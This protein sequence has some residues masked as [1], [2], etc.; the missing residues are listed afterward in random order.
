MPDLAYEKL[1]QS[2]FMTLGLM[3]PAARKPGQRADV[4]IELA[5]A[6]RADQYGFSALW[7]SQAPS[8]YIP[9]AERAVFDDPFVWLTA[10]GAAAPNAALVAQL[11]LSRYG[12][13]QLVSSARSLQRMSGGRCVLGLS[14][15]DG[16]DIGRLH[17]EKMLAAD[18]A[19]QVPILHLDGAVDRHPVVRQLYLELDER[20]SAP[21]QPIKHGWRGGRIALSA[22]LDRLAESG[23]AH[24]LIHLVR[25]G[26]PSLDLIDE[27]GTEVIPRLAVG[28]AL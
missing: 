6:K 20:A 28:V 7:A 25:N 19:E 17:L 2:G 15:A 14:D 23:V 27:I 26:R 8:P 21:R 18:G 1:F 11:D 10:I 3:T 4:A 13:A 16:G 5:V 9:D 24:V 22:Q 12:S